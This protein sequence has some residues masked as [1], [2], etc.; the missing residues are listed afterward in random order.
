MKIALPHSKAMR[1]CQPCLTREPK[2]HFH[3]RRSNYLNALSYYKA[4][5]SSLQSP[6]FRMAKVGLQEFQ[7]QELQATLFLLIGSE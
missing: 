4:F 2:D 1:T 5:R 6:I 7:L 3:F